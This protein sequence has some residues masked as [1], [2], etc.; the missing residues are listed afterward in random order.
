MWI[1]AASDRRASTKTSFIIS[2]YVIQFEIQEEFWK[3]VCCCHVQVKR[4]EPC[5]V[6]FHMRGWILFTSPTSVWDIERG[7]LSNGKCSITTWYSHGWNQISRVWDSSCRWMSSWRHGRWLSVS[8]FRGL[9]CQLKREALCPTL[10]GNS[11]IPQYEIP[12]VAHA[13][14]PAQVSISLYSSQPFLV[15][16]VS[17]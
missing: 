7:S 8:T 9:S 13:T 16:C 12:V 15:P 2:G 4:S 10:S 1:G 6:K 3:Y 14:I 17:G 11:S 5:I